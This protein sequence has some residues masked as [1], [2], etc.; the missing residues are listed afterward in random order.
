MAAATASGH[1]VARTGQRR[2][3]PEGVERLGIRIP[4]RLYR[5]VQEGIGNNTDPLL[6]EVIF[7]VVEFLNTGRPLQHVR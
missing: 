5:H 4:Y 1:R 2:D 7:R 6:R 3:G